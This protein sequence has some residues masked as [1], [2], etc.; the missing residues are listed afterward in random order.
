VRLEAIEALWHGHEEDLTDDERFLTAYIR[1][2]A[3]GT[4]DDAMFS[5]LADRGDVRTAVEYSAFIAFLVMTM[6]LWQALGVPDP[7]REEIDD[8][9]AAYRAGSGPELDPA[10][11]IG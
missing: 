8:L 1:A 4:V 10:A 11:R 2:V 7:S 6:R 9:L 3:S 5:R